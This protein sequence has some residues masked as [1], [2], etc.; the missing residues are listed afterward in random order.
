MRTSPRSIS[1][2]RVSLSR[3]TSLDLVCGSPLSRSAKAARPLRG[4]PPSGRR[5]DDRPY[6]VGVSVRETF[7]LVIVSIDTH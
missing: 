1:P 2:G 3:S 5:A 4:Q 6:G 7:R